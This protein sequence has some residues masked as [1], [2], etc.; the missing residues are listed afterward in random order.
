MTAF[1]AA[2]TPPVEAP[3]PATPIAK[4]TFALGS[5][6]FLLDGPPFQIIACELHPARI[7]AEYWRHRIRMAKAMGLNTIALYVFWNYQETAEGHFDFRTGNRD[8][9]RFVRLAQDE[10][11][12]VLLRPGPY[13]CAEWDFGGLPSISPARSRPAYPRARTRPTWP[14]PSATSAPSRAKSGR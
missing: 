4:H 3:A 11:M 5:T 12:W 14:Q 9:A 8:I 6:D 13:V 7:P 10:G 2:A 1:L